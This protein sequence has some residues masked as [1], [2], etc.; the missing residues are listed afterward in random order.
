LGSVIY[1]FS[2]SSALGG[3]NRGDAARKEM[4]AHG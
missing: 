3:P 1:P 4:Q 2:V